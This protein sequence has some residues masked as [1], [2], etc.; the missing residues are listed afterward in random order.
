VQMFRRNTDRNMAVCDDDDITH[1]LLWR[2]RKTTRGGGTPMG[3]E[4]SFAPPYPVNGGCAGYP[5]F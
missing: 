2:E 5:G 1:F 3:G 4:L